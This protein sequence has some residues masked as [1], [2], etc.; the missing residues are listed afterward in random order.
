[1]ATSQILMFHWV[2]RDPDG[3]I[4]LDD[5]DKTL[6]GVAPGDDEERVTPRFDLNK[7][8]IYTTRVELLM[9]PDNPVVVD[10]YD[11]DLCSVT[12]VVPPECSV[13][14]DCPEGYVCV[15][16]VCVPEE[17]VEKKF[18]WGWV[19][20]GAGAIV[21]TIGLASAAKKG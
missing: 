14:A 18:P 19:A 12:S 5:T 21:A 1:M 3:L 10:S 2:V 17:E 20:L 15:D 11:G 6:F 7:I 9:N 13:D 8:G 16:G 4:V